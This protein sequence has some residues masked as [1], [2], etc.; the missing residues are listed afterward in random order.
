MERD[1]IDCLLDEEC[2]DPVTLVDENGKS[3]L[4]EQV[5]VI[6][7]DN[8][9]YAILIEEEKCES[10]DFD[11][12]VVF[13]VDEENREIKECNNVNIISE[14]FAIYDRMYEEESAK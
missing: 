12:G 11:A 3:V 9:M 6:P 10:G 8:K 1:A 2:A 4:F 7:Y 5:A 14:I 13:S